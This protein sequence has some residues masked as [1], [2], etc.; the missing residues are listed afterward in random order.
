M[1][2]LLNY[3]LTCLALITPEPKQVGEE[4]GTAHP[5]AQS[6]AAHGWQ[7]NMVAGRATV[8]THLCMGDR[9]GWKLGEAMLGLRPIYLCYHLNF[10]KVRP[11]HKAFN[12]TN[13]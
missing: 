7:K 5:G 6:A 13:V 4:T 1:R 10:Y 3:V 12:S 9:R 2:T 11:C 8:V